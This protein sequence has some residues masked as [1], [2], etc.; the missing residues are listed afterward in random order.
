MSSSIEPT[1]VGS[2]SLAPTSVGRATPRLFASPRTWIEGAALEQLR[3][4]AGRPGIRAVAAFPD[5]H[6]GRHGPVGCAVLADRIHPA[7]IGNDIGCGMSL[8]LLDRPARK[9]RP[10]KVA[11]RL[12]ALEGEWDGPASGRLGEAGLPSDLAP[13]SLG[14][15]GGGNHFC[16]LQ[17]VAQ[18]GD[19]APRA[20]DRQSALLLVHS[21]SRI[22]GTRAFDAV[23]DVTAGLDADA[24]EGRGYLAAHDEA[25]R[26][27]ALNRRI[28]AERAA[29]ALRCDCALLADTPHN[30]VELRLGG[31]LHRKG[32][33]KADAGLVP[34][35]GSRDASSHLLRPTAAVPEALASLAHG[36]GR[37][38]DRASMHGRVGRTRSDRDALAR[39]SFGGRVVCEDRDLMIEEAPAAYKPVEQVLADLAA[40]GLAR[41]IAELQPVVTFKRAGSRGPETPK[42]P[43]RRGRDARRNARRNARHAGTGR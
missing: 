28:I 19:D 32:A 24:E 9:L 26:W 42:A 39:T 23:R 4:V 11:E 7:L 35:A 17:A 5:L 22:V 36:A 25:V 13:R 43:D 30:L 6:P 21:G 37:K 8:F 27:A 40:A 31:V 33:A 12:R 20:L 2:T 10:D 16:E 3:E 15:I 38:Y 29:E 14:T 34:L 1:I 18:L 41:S